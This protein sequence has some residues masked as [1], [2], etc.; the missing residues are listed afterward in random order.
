MDMTLRTLSPVHIGS[1]N[2]IETF[3]YVTRE[4][5]YSRVNFEAFSE[6]LFDLNP[7]HLTRLSMWI[8]DTAERIDKLDR[9]R[10]KDRDRRREF[11]NEL[12]EVRRNFTL[13]HFATHR[14]QLAALSDQL[15]AD[16]DLAYYRCAIN[17][18]RQYPLKEQIKTANHELYIPGSSL[19]G[20]L[21]TAL[22]FQVLTKADEGFK[23][24][25]RKRL[26]H[27]PDK[28]RRL[29]NPRDRRRLEAELGEEI[30]QAVFR[31][32][33]KTKKS[34]SFSDVHFDLMRG[35]QVS[36]TFDANA[37]LA[38]LLANTF[39]RQVD[40]R[41]PGRTPS[42]VSQVPVLLETLLP[43]SS[44]SVRLNVNLGFVRR[45]QPGGNEWIELDERFERLFGFSR[46]KLQKMD[47]ATASSLTLKRILNACQTFSV[48]IVKE[49]M[50]WAEQF[51]RSDTGRILNFYNRLKALPDCV[52]VRLG[53]GSH[54]MSTTVLLALRDDPVLG[55]VMTDIVRAF[56]L[57]LIGNRKGKSG[58]PRT[59]TVRLETFPRSRRMAALAGKAG[60]PFGWMTLSDP[61]VEP[62]D[63]LVD[64]DEL[65]RLYRS[66][67]PQRGGQPHGRPQYGGRRESA[68][69]ETARSQREMQV[70]LRGLSKVRRQSKP[71]VKVREGQRVNAEVISNDGRTV[72]VRLIDN[73]NEEV[74][75]QQSAYPHKPGAKVKM[76]VDRV[77]QRTGRITRVR[78]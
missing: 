69:R 5:V 59:R 16:D 39:V 50:R 53:W 24:R 32:G 78:P 41:P 2:D 28:A 13:S 68:P 29:R 76:K 48:A 27:Y 8:T 3:D 58:H 9:Q 6:R 33:V 35:V 62:G 20:A 67:Q 22:A 75:F 61:A 34:T 45:A 12:S 18:D 51:D 19:K 21:R 56:E 57:D 54:F 44:F 60:A 38:V 4:G 42:L 73:Q 55:E 46:G 47:D 26:E 43:Q 1:G 15:M 71:K 25:L 36:D 63:P 65:T 14:A 37:Q 31:C 40:S 66:R 30:E 74:K 70:A 23:K 72:A 64:V 10:K 7:D 77:D 11:Q 52:P 17:T 49:E